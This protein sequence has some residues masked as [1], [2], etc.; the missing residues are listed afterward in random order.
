MKDHRILRALEATA[1][2]LFTLQA[3]RVLFSVLFGIIYEAVFEGLFGISTM[4]AGIALLLAF[5]TPLLTP[6]EPRR[7]RWILLGTACIIALARIPMTLND[8]TIRLWSSLVIVAG[9]GL[10]LASLLRESPALLVPAMLAALAADQLFRAAGQTFDVTLRSHWWPLLAVLWLAVTVIAAKT[11]SLAFLLEDVRISMGRVGNPTLGWLGG[12]ALGAFLFL[13]TSL[14]SFSNALARWSRSSYSVLTPALLLVTLQPLLPVVRDGLERLR[15]RLGIGGKAWGG[16]LLALSLAGLAGGYLLTGWIAAGGLLLTQL[17]VLLSL[18]YFVEDRPL[19]RPERIH[20]WLTVGLLFFLVINFAYAFT[21]TY[22]YTL[23]FFR[24]MGLP[25]VLIAALLTTLPALLRAGAPVIPP[26]PPL[27]RP[28]PLIPW[29][30]VWRVAQIGG[31]IGLVTLAAVFARPPAEHLRVPTDTIRVG[32]YNI[33]YGYDTFWH[34]NL[35]EMARTIEKSEADVVA[36]QEVDTCRITSYGVDNALWLARRLGM[37]VVYQ[38]TVEHLTGVALLTRVPIEGSGGW[39]L[40]SHEEQTGMAWAQVNTANGPLNA[41]GLWLGLSE[42]ERARQIEDALTKLDLS[43]GTPL[44]LGGDF[45]STPDSPTHQR[46]ESAGLLDPFA[47]LNREPAYSS[48][49]INPTEHIDF[50]WVRGLEPV[51][52]RVLPSL[53]SDHRMVVIEARLP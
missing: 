13:Q 49:A 3:V 35:E 23:E 15:A 53:A 22:A 42:E 41:Y 19:T 45:N 46:L 48:P 17:A 21:F 32:T 44:V 16:A 26:P 40:T 2:V 4:I 28:T 27:P 33:H 47:L 7:L 30:K 31:L 37:Q 25:I 9:S 6:R 36:L 29:D 11:C 39:L 1:V 51:E 5:L 34:L 10:Y 20:I 18:R 43:S 24:G 14:L 8:P 38:P 12:L 50:V 52:A